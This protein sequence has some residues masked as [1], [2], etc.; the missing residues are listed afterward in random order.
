MKPDAQ[1]DFL[2]TI[3]IFR[4]LD[5]AMLAELAVWL[6]ERTLT[7]GELAVKQGD[8]GDEL[9][10]VV[11]GEFQVFVSEPSLDLEKEVG[12]LGAGR[13]FG[14][15][16]L[17]SEM[18]RLVSVRATKPSHALVLRREAFADVTGRSPEFAMAL[19]RGLATYLVD[20]TERDKV[21]PFVGLELG[22]ISQDVARLLPAGLG[23]ALRA[24]AFDRRGDTV[25]VA[26]V[27]PYDTAGRNFVKQV[28]R[29]ARVEFLATSKEDFDR[30]SARF[31]S[32]ASGADL[33]VGEDLDPR[34]FTYTTEAGAVEPI[35]NDKKDVLLRVLKRALEA[36]ASD[37]HFEPLGTT[38]RIRARIDG[39]LIVLEDG[40][41][42]ETFAR[43]ARRLKVMTTLDI[44]HKQPLQDGSCQIRIGDRKLEMR[45]SVVAARGGDSV[46]ARFVGTSVQRLDLESLV[47]SR[48]LT[49]LMK[50]IF[51]S[52]NGLVLVAGPT[53]AGKTTTLYAGLQEIWSRGNDVKIITIEDPVEQHLDYA[54]QIQVSKE[55]GLDFAQVLR[56]VLRQDPDVILVGEMRDAESAAVAVRAAITGHVVLSSVHAYA[57]NEAIVAL[58][59]LGVPPFLISGALRGIVCQ[60]LIARVCPACSVPVDPRD[61]SVAWL[62]KHDPIPPARLSL[63]RHGKGCDAC[64]FTGEAGRVAVFEVLAISERLVELIEADAPWKEMQQALTP[65]V[66]VPM[67]RYA[68]FL[69]AQ[70]LMSPKRL[71]EAFPGRARLEGVQL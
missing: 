15:I 2:R 32:Q 1:Q 39:Q 49:L 24:I 27:D 31:Y 17:I 65:E 61:E 25:K 29:Q 41:P 58:K 57:C 67:S 36:G 45:L 37:L 26:M 23:S 50:D 38:G 33:A 70:G 20:V 5:P 8:K 9:F 18:P 44:T 68:R 63:L 16:A 43:V 69:M 59:N 19:C 42:A 56:S 28:L 48:P 62:Q 47:L 66:F 22:K 21:F 7:P 35:S 12:R 53:G 14:E 54:T 40:L 11:D 3:P 51:L 6:E 52:P 55:A 30:A 71:R 10:L 64:R 60:R 34:T 4:N 46:A 13:Y